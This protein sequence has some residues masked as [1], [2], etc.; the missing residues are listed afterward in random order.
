MMRQFKLARLAYLLLTGYKK[1]KAIVL[2]G[3]VTYQ[4]LNDDKVWKITSE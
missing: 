3:K 4:L 2:Y 1:E